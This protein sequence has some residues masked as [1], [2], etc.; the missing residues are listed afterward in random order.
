MVK[1]KRRPSFTH[2]DPMMVTFVLDGEEF[3]ALNGGPQYKLTEAI[4]LFV[5]C[6]SQEEVDMYWT[7]LSFDPNSEQCGLLKDKYGLSWQIIPQALMTL[8]SDPDREKTNRVMQ[9][10]LKMKKIEVT[11][12][13]AAYENIQ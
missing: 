12:L 2:A 4:S 1:P 5:N 8:M 9:A 13:Q 3:M 7:K 11:E 10:M 6:E